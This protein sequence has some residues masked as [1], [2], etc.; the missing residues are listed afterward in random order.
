MALLLPPEELFSRVS[1]WYRIPWSRCGI[2]PS[3]LSVELSNQNIFSAGILMVVYRGS[4]YSMI[5]WNLLLFI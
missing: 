5:N 1:A 3:S 4:F 2:W